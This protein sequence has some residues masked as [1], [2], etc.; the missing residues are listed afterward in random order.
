MSRS[1]ESARHQGLYLI[2]ISFLRKPDS[3]LVSVVGRSAP[4]A[5][6]Q[7]FSFSILD[8]ASRALTVDGFGR[9]EIQ[10]KTRRTDDQPFSPYP[11]G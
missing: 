10:D 9:S 11:T 4:A 8:G 2:L 6:H 7:Q 5:S 1:R 3:L